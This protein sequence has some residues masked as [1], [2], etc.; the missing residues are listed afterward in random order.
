M[1]RLMNPRAVLGLLSMMMLFYST[2]ACGE[3][4]HPR[5]EWAF[6]TEGP[7]RSA[8]VVAGDN[9]YF[10]S[11]DGFVYA[12]AKKN[13]TLLWKFDTG[14]PIAGAP[15]VAGSTVVVTGRGRNVFAL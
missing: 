6:Q 12:L 4:V 8:A 3:P 1:E 15:A 11:T 10:G 2:H 14:A 7:V 13:G 9:I 5:V